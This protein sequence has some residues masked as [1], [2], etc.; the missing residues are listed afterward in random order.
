MLYPASHLPP[1]PVAVGDLLLVIGV[2]LGLA[3]YI[4]QGIMTLLLI[5]SLDATKDINAGMETL[6]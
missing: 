2:L 1:C 5:T 4:V 6:F 3:F